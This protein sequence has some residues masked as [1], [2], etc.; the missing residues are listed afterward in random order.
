MPEPSDQVGETLFDLAKLADAEPGEEQSDAPTEPETV[1]VERRF[2]A[3]NDPAKAVDNADHGVEGV[4]VLSLFRNDLGTEAE[5]G[6][7]KPELDDE[8]VDVTEIAVFDVEGSD[9]EASAKT[10]EKSHDDEERQGEDLP[11]RQV[12]VPDHEMTK[13][14]RK[15]TT[16]AAL[17]TMSRGKKSLL[18]RLELPMRLPEATVREVAKSR[19]GK[20]PAETSRA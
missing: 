4:E 17:G 5:R 13:L 1:A 14:L 18:M 6:D 15:A 9:P 11:A 10:G 20:R 16:T 8:G 3:D 12:T 19:Q 7:V 2:A